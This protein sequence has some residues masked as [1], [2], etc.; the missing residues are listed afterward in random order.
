MSD[1]GYLL[2]VDRWVEDYFGIDLSAYP[3]LKQQEPGHP[4]SPQPPIAK[5]APAAPEQKKK[6]DTADLGGISAT[7][8]KPLADAMAGDGLD[9]ST[10]RWVCSF[11]ALGRVEGGRVR[12]GPLEIRLGP[13]SASVPETDANRRISDQNRGFNGSVI[14]TYVKE[15]VRR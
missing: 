5:P 6:D 8:Y 7:H 4:A 9:L 12:A 10:A 3:G 2:K 14:W 11:G 1:P 15:A 13:G